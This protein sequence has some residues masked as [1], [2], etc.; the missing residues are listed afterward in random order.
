MTSNVLISIVVFLVI[1]A[2]AVS[3]HDEWRDR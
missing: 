3:M 1:I 2:F